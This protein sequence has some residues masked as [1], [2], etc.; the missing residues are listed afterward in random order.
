MPLNDARNWFSLG[1]SF[2]CTSNPNGLLN[3]NAILLK[4]S[5]LAG[6]VE[7]TVCIFTEGYDSTNECPDVTINN[8]MVW[9]TLL[10][11]NPR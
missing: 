10:L 8:L 1:Y 7:Y 3:T 9:L 5:L 2:N 4:M 11:S 6:A